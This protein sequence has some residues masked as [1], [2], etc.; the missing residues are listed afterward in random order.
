MISL[1]KILNKV[2]VDLKNTF[3]KSDTIPVKNGG[4]GATTA[5]A[6]RANLGISDCVVETGSGSVVNGTYNYRMWS[7][8]L[9]EYWYT[10]EMSTGVT[11]KVWAT[12]ICYNDYKTWAGLFDASRN[13]LFTSRPHVTISSRNSQ[14]LAFIP[15]SIT[16]AGI[17]T[18]RPVSVNAKSNNSYSFSLYAV[19]TWK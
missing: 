13:G 4:T 16:T 12:P 19:G 9:S 14:F 6:A 10:I 3:K 15:Y 11:T 17:G 8:G 7:S 2:L 18:I 5:A 1:K